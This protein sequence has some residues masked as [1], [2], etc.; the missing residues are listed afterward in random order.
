MLLL[1]LVSTLLASLPAQDP[2]RAKHAYA[3]A[4]DLEREGNHPAALALLWEA[5]GLAPTDAEVQNRLGEA[6]DRIGALDGAIDAFRRALIARPAFRKASNNLILTLVKAGRGPEA[7]ERARVLVAAA[8]GDPDAYFT[9]GLAQSEQDVTEAIAAFRRVLAIDPRHVLARYNLALVLKR[10][11]RASEAIDELTRAIQVDARPEA[12]YTLGVIHWQQ[13]E[14]DQAE[15]ALRAALAA[16]PGH[17][18]AHYTLG[19]VLGARRDVKGA[20]ASL[21]RAIE[22][23]PDLWSARYTLARI[24]RESGDEAAARAHLAEAERLRRRAQLERE[25]SVATSVGTAKLEAGDLTGALDQFRRA[26]AIDDGY[27]PAHYQMGRTLQRLGQH[28]ASRAAFARAQRLNPSLVP[29][30]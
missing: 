3:R 30:G 19:A 5:A 27:A 22:L 26:A 21:R 10:I 13:G 6:L 2:S 7:V 8:P 15:R 4:L 17:A 20:V 9:L 1:L 11:D 16:Q 28:E 23:R 25:A 14:I 29:P 24:L 18:D 12:H